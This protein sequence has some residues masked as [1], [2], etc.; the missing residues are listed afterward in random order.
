MLLRR[1]GGPSRQ[2]LCLMNE[3]S[4]KQ[5][6]SELLIAAIIGTYQKKELIFQDDR[7]PSLKIYM[8]KEPNHNKPHVHIY[9]GNE[10]AVSICVKTR[11][12]LAGSI[13]QKLLKP[14][15]QWVEKHEHGLLQAWSEI[16]LG[17]KP[18]LLWNA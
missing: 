4:F 8:Y 9:F 14:L 7:R 16:Q 13:K 6:R 11:E 1:C 2:T 10:E 15:K 12:I 5:L 18:E 3:E 17:K